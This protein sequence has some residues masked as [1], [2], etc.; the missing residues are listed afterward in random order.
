[1]GQNNTVL[2]IAGVIVAFVI[3]YLW[4]ES[5]RNT[6]QANLASAAI[7]AHRARTPQYHTVEFI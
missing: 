1:M 2:L 4:T 5:W 7:A 6:M 3:Y